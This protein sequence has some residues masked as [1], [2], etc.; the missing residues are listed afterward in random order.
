VEEGWPYAGIG[1]EISALVMERAFDE[2]DAPVVRVHGS[3]VPLP[4]A[5]NLEQLALPQPEAIIK[6]AKSV[7]YRR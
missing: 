5:A 3:D 1:A 2:L 7:C 4:Y 6:A